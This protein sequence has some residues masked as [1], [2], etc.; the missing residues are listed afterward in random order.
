M[1]RFNGELAAGAALMVLASAV[2]FFHLGAYGL[3]EPDEGRYAEIPREMLAARDFIVPHL[4]YVAYVEKPPLLYWL[5]ALSFRFFGPNELA[6]RMVPALSAMLGVIATYVFALRVFDRRRAAL[7][8]AILATSPLYA[9]LAQVL[10]TDMLLAALVTIAFFSF[11]LA[12]REGGGWRWVFYG[13]MGLGVLAKGPVGAVLPIAAAMVFLWW[14]GELRS[15][16]S[17]LKPVSGLILTAAIAAP[18]FVAVAIRQPGFIWFYF[19]GEHIRRFFQATY[20]H[21]EPI[22][23]YIPVL[24]AGM[25]PWTLTVPMIRWR[26]AS[27]SA[28]TFCL[29]A[30]AVVVVL[31]SL[32]SAKLI[33]YILPA[34]PPIAVLLADT[35]LSSPRPTEASTASSG[36]RSRLQFA[37]LL[38]GLA[39]AATLALAVLAPR[40]GGQYLALLR[41]VLFAIGAILILGGLLAA[42]MFRRGRLE[43]ALTAMSLTIAASLLAGTYARIAVEPMRSYAE[44][45]RA[46]AA[47]EPDS[48]LICYHRYIQALPFY[49]RRR[50]IVVGSR[51]EL[52]FG[53]EHSADAHDYFFNSDAD[54]IRLWNR[55]VRSVLLIDQSDL[56]RLRPMLGNIRVIASEHTKRAVVKADNQVAEPSRSDAPGN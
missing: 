49:A 30:A 8:G 56:D 6:A 17:K 51:S 5:T 32:A 41:G 40:F 7:A 47:Q 45:S 9:V 43:L 12:W 21:G 23:F 34:L 44:L 26:V 50:V 28:R 19:V 48:T 55:P 2:F 3:W 35:I 54:L 15:G 25:L 11:F 39:G 22:Y 53:A 29:I 46:V 52:G 18:W 13:A 16:I 36:A 14:Q 24:L 31:F 37:G 38:T 20:S 1:R 4:N 33:P 10:T 27:D 42:A